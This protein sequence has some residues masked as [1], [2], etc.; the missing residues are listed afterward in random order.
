MAATP[1]SFMSTDSR[2]AGS[3]SLSQQQ[4]QQQQH[5]S[6]V[7]AVVEVVSSGEVAAQVEACDLTLSSASNSADNLGVQHGNSDADAAAVAALE[8]EEAAEAK[9]ASEEDNN[10]DHSSPITVTVTSGSTQY[11]A[12][13]V[14]GNET[15]G[16]D[17]SVH[18]TYV[19]YVDGSPDSALYAATN[20]QMTYPA[21]TVVESGAMYSPGNNQY[22]T[23]GTGNNSITYS[24]VTPGQLTQTS[25]GTF[26]IQQGVD[27][28]GHTLI[29][30]TTRASPQTEG[31]GSSSAYLVTGSQSGHSPSSAAVGGGV[32]S[33]SH[34]SLAHATR[35]SPATVQWLIDN[36]ETAEGVSLPRSTLYAHYLR[37]CNEHKLEPVNAASFG[38]LIRSVFLGL[39][40]RRLGTR[41][42]SKYHYYGIRVKPTS[43]LNQMSVEESSPPSVQ[44]HSTNGKRG[45][46][47]GAHSSGGSMDATSPTHQQYLGDAAAALPHWPDLEADRNQL[48]QGIDVDDLQAFVTL[49]RDH[50]EAMLDAVISLQFNTV[51]TIWRHF[52]RSAN[53]NEA[54]DVGMEEDPEKILPKAKLYVLSRCEPVLIF[55]K[56]ADYQFYQNLVEVLIPDVL[57]EIPGSFTSSIR[58]FAKSLE[59]WLLTA[60]NGCPEDIIIVKVAAVNAFSQ[61]LRRYTSLNHLAQAARA[62]L[63][64][65]PQITQMLA[66]LNR[67]DFHNIQE[68]GAWVCRCDPDLV[69]W[70]ENDFKVTLHNQATLEQWVQ[71]LERVVDRVIKPF[72]SGS[73]QE[74]V[75]VA[76]QFLL[77]WSFYSSMVIRDLTLRSA[78]SFGSFH[79]IRLLYDEYI[80]YLVE[81][82]VAMVT[83]ETPIAVMS[84]FVNMTLRPK[85]EDEAGS[86]P[87]SPSG[88][89]SA[90]LHVG[91]STPLSA[92]QQHKSGAN[93]N[94]QQ[95][96][97]PQ[98][99]DGGSSSSS[100]NS[101]KRPK[102]S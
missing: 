10:T 58:S 77:K 29:T 32:D 14:S 84:E 36:Y 41:G 21:Y 47:G 12:M 1:V 23:S 81:H 55:V 57:K 54:V 80:F 83:G 52:W 88:S 91:I 97:H 98:M 7:A 8:A 34:Y 62:V 100:S 24:Q 71:W 31:N 5:G 2:P 35:V 82:R 22:Y 4:Q 13:A 51:E 93:N 56:K 60:M 16:G 86:V 42:N 78:A 18:S 74:F 3:S 96:Q 38:K 63:H 92:Q 95:Q 64:N 102:L 75:R 79:L 87:P 19:Q 89:S 73:T 45:A 101:V 20:G 67:V 28:D 26:L 49:Y 17:S 65:P 69:A 15:L 59:N 61:T 85:D 25:G 9:D 44:R 68:Q 27:A 43:S 99:A 6:I 72:E 37:H 50:C 11:I 30:T 39:R 40:T 70:L 48:P 90:S 46:K 33:D 94:S 66:D 76:R 53:N